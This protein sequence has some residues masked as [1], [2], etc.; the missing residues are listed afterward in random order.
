MS[1]A[2]L[3]RV[4]ELK[5][6]LAKRTA[7]LR[8]AL[9]RL[10]IEQKD[11]NTYVKQEDADYVRG[12]RRDVEEIKSLLDAETLAGSVHAYLNAPADD[13]LAT[14]A[15]MPSSPQ[16]STLGEMFT[17][18][19]MYQDFMKSGRLTMPESWTLDVKDLPSYGRPEQKD[20]YAGAAG[21]AITRTMGS[22]QFDPIV[23]RGQ[24]P[25]RV[26]T[27][28]PVA[29]TTSNLIDYFRVTGFTEG[30]GDGAAAPTPDYDTGNFGLKP[31]SNLV[32][33]N[34]QAPVRTIAHWEA[35]HRN[36]IQDVPQ[37]QAT[38]NNELLYGLSL[39]EDDQILNGDGNGDNLLGV[40]QTPNVQT[41]TPGV[42]ELGSDTLRKAITKAVVAYY[43][44]TG[45]VIHPT[46][47]ETIEL[48]KATT[49]D[50]QYALFTNVAIGLQAQIWR[51]PVVETVAI[52]EGDYLVGAFG[53]GA[54]LYDRQSAA[55]R[56]S[57]QHSDFF[58]RNAVVILA[59]QRLA[60]A[61]KRPEAFVTGSF[62]TA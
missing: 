17:Q 56:I 44:P 48:Q 42:A 2:T 31:Q 23:P 16:V 30:S 27:L 38:I 21:N 59:E 6:A 46:D 36:V 50:Q 3:D 25:N 51:Q 47:W 12:I 32:F 29:T 53:T 24:R 35:A 18:S 1:T 7:D 55:V 43:P 52:A 62:V 54:Q 4:D 11:D 41:Y 58:V 57:E 49:G 40:L 26:R 5:S 10:P 8:D 28:F 22:I 39:A 9:D 60:L 37:M 33:T 20:V 19:E 61:V 15:S 13:A 14:K 45:I 34:A